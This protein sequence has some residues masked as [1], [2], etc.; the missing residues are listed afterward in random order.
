MVLDRPVRRGEVLVP[1]SERME[2]VVTRRLKAS[3]FWLDGKG[4]SLDT[5]LT[6][7]CATQEVS[8]RI[9][10]IY[11]KFDPASIE[12]IEEDADGIEPAEVA[13]VEIALDGPVVVDRFSEVP[14]MGRF[15]LEQDGYPVAGGIIS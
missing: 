6:W 9:K 3:I 7:K 14:E 15:V 8:G 5:P 12:L 13:E 11:R 2:C 1:A 4:Y 10:K